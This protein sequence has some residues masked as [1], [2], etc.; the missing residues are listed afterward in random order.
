M[1]TQD[2]S[3]QKNRV[4]Y[5][6][7]DLFFGLR[8][9]EVNTPYVTG[10][11]G[12][13]IEVL[14]RIH[15]VQSV[16][17]DF[18]VQRQD[19]SVLGKS[20]F[21]ENIITNPPDISLTITHS[22]EGLNNEKKMGFN[23]LSLGASGLAN[24][25]FSFPFT[26]SQIKQQNVYLAVNQSN[27][28][29]REHKRPAS[30][31]SN[32][33]ASGRYQELSHKG[34]NEMGLIVFQ[35][36]Y[37][38]NYAMDVTLG[39]FPKADVSF[40]S[41]NVIYLN[42]ASGQHVPWID[43]KTAT[44]YNRKNNLNQDT[45]FLVPGNFQRQNPYFNPDYNFKP[46]D[47]KFIISTRVSPQDTMM[48][49]DFETSVKLTDHIGTQEID[50]TTAYIG[51]KSLKITS[52]T[53]SQDGARGGV[54]T[55]LP[56]MDVNKYYT[57]T[58]YAKTNSVEKINVIVSAKGADQSTNEFNTFDE[59]EYNQG[60]VKITKT[61][62]VTSFKENLFIYT[63]AP[64]VNLWLDEI[65]LSKEP[66]NPPLKFHTDLMQ[67]FKLNIPLNR[68]NISCM[69][70]KYYADRPLS[71]PVKT[72]YSI[73]MLSQDLEFP[74]G[75]EGE[76][77]R[78]N[79]LDNLRKDEEYDV[80]LTFVDSGSKEGMKFRILGSKFEG[81]SYGLDINAPKTTTI[82]FSLSNDYDYNRSVISAEGRG[83]FILDFLVSDALEPL[84]DDNGN[85]FGD[86]YPFNF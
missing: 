82:N 36:C 4:V 75:V 24:K 34:T 80:F 86:Q 9:G 72:T 73:D 23:V 6:V 71:L 54:K 59:I 3:Q 77:R 46:G 62:K 74:V 64:N 57:F 28:D 8:S 13:N 31:I 38:T 79:F 50:G 44:T 20:N 43:T 45:E 53:A 30:Q 21:D 48:K 10:S 1:S 7:Q 18:Q 84:T 19:I 60:W 5:N 40:V 32:L 16:S 22:L 41:D 68:Q 58:M 42:S 2:A 61:F 55:T 66:E 67:S 49:Y 63:T 39:S 76:D 25:E 15:R 83:L 65:I 70:H 47:A 35:N 69:G 78:G 27:S 85:N 11:D 81:V 52:S 14:K 37:A 17:Y 26:D 56:T 33:I 51:T 29:I 12:Q